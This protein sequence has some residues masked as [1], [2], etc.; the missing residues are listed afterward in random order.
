[1]PEDPVVVDEGRVGCLQRLVRGFA[2]A[3]RARWAKFRG[4]KGRE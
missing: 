3:Q 4:K 2:A 1:M